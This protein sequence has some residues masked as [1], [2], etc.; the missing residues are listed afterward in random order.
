MDLF[1]HVL[2]DSDDARLE[3]VTVTLLRRDR[4]ETTRLVTGQTGV[5][6]GFRLR[7]DDTGPRP[8]E[9]VL[10]TFFRGQRLP[11]LSGRSRWSPERPPERW[12]LRVQPASFERIDDAAPAHPGGT[13]D[14]IRGEVRHTNGRLFDPPVMKLWERELGKSTEVTATVQHPSPGG[15]LI[16][17]DQG[18]IT[19]LY[20]TIED[21]SGNVIGRSKLLVGASADERIDILV[22]DAAFSGVSE[23]EQIDA[24]VS[25]ALAGADLPSMSA[26]DVAHLAQKHELPLG[27][28]RQY[29]RAQQLAAGLTPG[30]AALYG[31]LRRGLPTK[32][33]E[34]VARR[35]VTLQS[36]LEAAAAAGQVPAS[37]GSAAATTAANLR[38]DGVARALDASTRSSLGQALL[39][40]APSLTATHRQAFVETWLDSSGD[41][42]FWTDLA[43]HASY[44]SGDVDAARL[45]IRQ[46]LMMLG[47][48]PM[49]AAFQQVNP[50]AT[51]EDAAALDSAA[52][53][54]LMSEQI[55][56]QDAGAPS[57]MP[58]AN[59]SER[60]SN[61]AAQLVSQAEA[62]HPSRAVVEA[63]LAA[64]PTDS[65]E[66][67]LFLRTNAGFDFRMTQ[68]D[69]FVDGGDT[70][71]ITDVF[72]LKKRLR[73]L[74]RLYRVIGKDAGRH[75]RLMNLDNA[76]V[77][78]A[79]GIARRSRAGFIADFAGMLGGAEPAALVHQRATTQAAASQALW[80]MHSRDLRP[81]LPALGAMSDPSTVTGIEGYGTLFAAQGS[82]ACEGCLSMLG[83]AAYFV[84]LL[85]WL[86]DLDAYTDLDAKR[87][88]LKLLELSCENT[89]TVLPYTDLAVEIFEVAV[90]GGSAVVPTSTTR[91]T[92]ELLAQPEHVVTAA[93]TT[94][95]SAWWPQTLPYDHSLTQVRATMD[96]LGVSWA[97]LLQTLAT[98]TVPGATHLTNAWLGLSDGLHTALTNTHSTL[99]RDHWGYAS[100]SGPHPVI[101]SETVPW[102]VAL[103]YVPELMS[104]AQ[105]HDV[106]H[107]RDVLH[108][109]YV[110]G[111]ND[112][113]PLVAADGLGCEL[114]QLYV[115]EV[116]VDAASA[117]ADPGEDAFTR[118]QCFLRLQAVLGW[119]ALELDKVLHSLGVAGSVGDSG[120]DA[121]SLSLLADVVRVRSRL[122]TVPLAEVASWWAPTMDVFLD[123][124][125]R[126]NPVA[127][128]YDARF[129]DPSLV[130]PATSP[131]MLNA[132]R[133][134]LVP[135]TPT[136]PASDLLANHESE[137]LAALSVDS[138]ALWEAAAQVADDLSLSG[139]EALERKLDHLS[140]LMRKVSVAR[141]VGLSIGDCGSLAT[142]FG[143]S[144]EGSAA[145]GSALTF[146]ERQAELTGWGLQPIDL[147]WLLA[148]DPDVLG[149]LNP[150]D[151]AIG[152][153]LGGLRDQLQEEQVALA[154]PAEAT[155]DDLRTRLAELVA[156]SD[157]VEVLI[158]IAEK[159]SALSAND[160]EAKVDEHLSDY[161]DATVVRTQLI[162]GSQTFLWFLQQVLTGVLAV[163]SQARVE[164]QLG[165]AFGL[166]SGHFDALRTLVFDALTS[167]T[168]VDVLTAPGFV[169]ALQDPDEPWADLT[170][171]AQP[172]GYAA[173]ELVAKV[174]L[175]VGQLGCS[176]EA[177]TQW[178]TDQAE[179][180][181][182]DLSALPVV[183]DTTGLS[184]RY[185][186]LRSTA[187]W[188]GLA[189]R[190]SG[191]TPE[192]LDLMGVLK[193]GQVATF[194]TD[195]ASRTGWAREDVD[196]L[197]LRD[198]TQDVDV[199]VL[200]LALDAVVT[201]DTTTVTVAAPPPWASVDAALVTLRDAVNAD[202]TASTLVDAVA[203]DANGGDVSVTSL[204]AVRLRLTRDSGATTAID[205]TSTTLMVRPDLFSVTAL[206]RLVGQL[207][208]L[209]RL[210]TTAA[211]ALAQ[212]TGTPDQAVADSVRTVARQR[213]AST[214]AWS[215]AYRP[216]RDKVR[217]R[218]Q[219]GLVTWLL[220][221]DSVADEEALYGKYL[222]DTGM[223]PC[224][225]TSRLKQGIASVQLY[226]QRCFLGLEATTLDD[227]A[228]ERW[229]WMRQYRL[230]EA[231]RKVFLQ[232]QNWLTPELRITKSESFQDAET[233][234]LE[235]EPTTERAE[236]VM[237]RYIEAFHELEN[238]NIIGLV[239]QVGTAR[240]PERVHLFARVLATDGVVYRRMDSRAHWTPWQE[241]GFEVKSDTICPFV[242][243]GRLFLIW[244]DIVMTKNGDGN[245]EGM[246]FVRWSERRNDGWTP[247]RNLEELP[248]T[249]QVDSR[250]N[251]YAL[252]VQ[253]W[254]DD[255]ELVLQLIQGVSQMVED[256]LQQIEISGEWH[257]RIG[258]HPVAIER[259]FSG[260]EE[261]SLGANSIFD[262]GGH[263]I[264]EFVNSG[265]DQ[266]VL[267]EPIGTLTVS[268]TD[269]SYTEYG[270]FPVMTRARTALTVRHT[271]AW[272]HLCQDPFV[273]QD[274]A[275][276]FLLWPV[277]LGED[278]QSYLE[279]SRPVPQQAGVRD[280]LVDFTLGGQSRTA[281][282]SSLNLDFDASPMFTDLQEYPNTA[283]NVLHTDAV[284]VPQ[285]TPPHSFEAQ[286]LH[287]AYLLDILEQL[288]SEG[289]GGLFRPAADSLH[290]ELFAQGA[291]DLSAFDAYVDADIAGAPL[292]VI[293]DHP[294]DNIAF[295]P[296]SASSFYNWE[297][298]FH[299][300][301]LVS[302]QLLAAQRFDEALRWVQLIFD[303]RKGSDAWA[304]KPFREPADQP[305]SD[306]QAFKSDPGAATAFADQVTAWLE[307]PFD[308]HHVASLRPEAY[309][310]YT[311]TA[312]LDVLLDWADARFAAD[313]L[314]SLNEA[315]QL[316]TYAKNVLGPRPIRAKGQVDKVV[317]SFS[318]LGALDELS[319]GLI[320]IEELVP[321]LDLTT[322]V[323]TGYAPLLEVEY[324]CV[325]LDD[326]LEGYWDRVEM[327]LFKLRN[328]MNIDGVVRV[329]PLFQ[330]PIDPGAI[331][332]A[333]ASG[334]DLGSA[335]NVNAVLPRHRFTVM[336]QR[337][338]ELAGNVRSLG[339]SLLSALE[340]RDGEEMSLLRQRHELVM[341]DANL[342]VREAQ[343]T[344]A[345]LGLEAAVLGRALAE[346]R[347]DYYAGLLKKGLLPLELSEEDQSEKAYKKDQNVAR[348]Q[349]LA[350]VAQL[351]PQLSLPTG[352]EFGGIH[353][354]TAASI[355]ASVV[356]LKAAEHRYN[357]GAAGRK[358]GQVRR[359]QDWKF[360]RDLAEAELDQ[361]DEQI[362]AA[363]V[364][365]QIT[366]RELEN[367][368]RQQAH[369]GE[370]F[371]FIKDKFTSQ[372]L[373]VWMV[374]ELSRMHSASYQLAL[375]VA[376]KAEACYRH[377][378]G[379]PTAS[380]TGWTHWDGLRKGMLVGER[381][382][383]DL[384][385]M[386]IAYLDNDRREYEITKHFALSQLDPT[387]LVQLQETGACEFHVAEV[388]YDLDFPG[389]YFRRLKNVSVSLPCVAGPYGSVNAMLTLTTS[390]VRTSSD[391]SGGYA[392]QVDDARF[393]TELAVEAVAISGA[394]NEAG[395]FELSPSDGRYLPFERRGAIGHWRLELPSD[396][397]SLDPRSLSDV[398][399]HLRY[400]SRDGGS[401]LQGAV[402]AQMDALLNA[403]R[404]E[405]ATAA[406]LQRVL[407]ARHD[408]PDAWH[409]F[410][411]PDEAAT[412]LTLSVELDRDWFPHPVRGKTLHITGVTV[413]IT[414]LAGASA[415]NTSLTV[416]GGTP[417]PIPL[418]AASPPDPFALEGTGT[419]AIDLDGSGPVTLQVDMTAAEIT[420]SGLGDGATLVRLDANKIE[421]LVLVLHYTVS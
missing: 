337:S 351:I 413:G 273:V 21:G 232:P 252:R 323:P 410:L 27:Q 230:W 26:S 89:N 331:A 199:K 311:V 73:R 267:E 16:T 156:D 24:V 216:V 345:E 33:S 326:R 383:R 67:T 302:R 324:F 23:Y 280:D 342:A 130:D 72:A 64:D 314:E 106:E 338:K 365:V 275:R 242:C 12:V 188:L 206:D 384:E 8:S 169:D 140:R 183:E 263:A 3:G 219:R 141:A 172:D 402:K 70:T 240:S 59:E 255:R 139:P 101:P 366:E 6:G 174:G 363:E 79:H 132:G 50:G 421:D 56:G 382:T 292:A 223:D 419:V 175:L 107:L 271:P 76:G 272:L 191:G 134:E 218:Q 87:P 396:L 40:G 369:S 333:L 209:G 229:L 379:E 124:P 162:D 236:N 348:L 105:L 247:H 238:P 157:E 146:L 190:A 125:A 104:R 114:E 81:L 243:N 344:E 166:E 165:E 182:L 291:A 260:P 71:L 262:H 22:T 388:G 359:V 224:M 414:T 120:I 320:A 66:L 96:H 408:L 88:D 318:Q 395:V 2:R 121:A 303:P 389:Q 416:L 412:D 298:F 74:R 329:L 181:L 264:R 210:G 129:L 36:A 28:L 54:S 346:Q 208:L 400:T 65:E 245:F 404:S 1:G 128:L 60:R 61:Y 48:A 353:L 177:L 375:Q 362:A 186:S 44:S 117:T 58:G 355:G 197:V 38:A 163:V 202:P 217:L 305:I 69:G 171:A 211:T 45:G 270:Q 102:F 93:Y 122:S 340:K 343:V 368:R 55:D 108:T 380:F 250:V 212:V 335:L 341:M 364:R 142:A 268:P 284:T 222:I 75:T 149:E 158:D 391:T 225:L 415:T 39:K 150:S 405:Y 277:E 231:N 226:I 239:R 401:V 155:I 53:Q 315:L 246:L 94:L 31:L 257:L 144:M 235:Q 317:K 194:A 248:I 159:D 187:R 203:L 356:G 207:G 173:V 176:A 25:T 32:A 193:L 249:N 170:R 334:A 135:P 196:T 123:R 373:Y 116:F 84:D 220:A 393:K 376:R 387:A 370:V 63:Q 328:C 322:M 330:P 251:Y 221:N 237:A 204:P 327:Q 367:Q 290:P 201:V 358:A 321:E 371:S 115:G 200:D 82:C 95:G 185:P 306:W 307:H 147:R 143:V 34:L 407:S 179:L 293:A 136:T 97:E 390:E 145:P 180:S 11:V 189:G 5:D 152:D 261:W 254:E 266:L 350:S 281:S 9:Y 244:V 19:D 269:V 357:S 77:S 133:T 17:Y 308:P 86:Q 138:E 13:V 195:L 378:I 111:P 62:C 241:L 360:Q 137:L 300:P 215:K 336:L 279:D 381:L 213:H 42:T 37:T 319:N 406:G 160:Q 394:Q 418:T 347:R 310:L 167:Q 259:E 295:E 35:P 131:F 301:I 148:H 92:D 103:R 100:A 258:A 29:L 296:A 51:D 309:K 354:G 399:L 46:W 312:Y 78:S 386:E 411:F 420:S 168:L 20:V 192:W 47:Y 83:P 205:I 377:E 14:A 110:Q 151:E 91:Q 214:A 265:V 392:Q 313:T 332:A 287:Q 184:T 397:R 98:A 198:G 109:R 304:L 43:G 409:G 349:V 90:A 233:R 286:A 161:V 278:M 127:P 227:E 113:T 126:D 49:V 417:A 57:W 41:A 372:Q 154:A 398:V 288:R 80:S 234:L 385:R 153:L 52:W 294:I 285:F 289:V 403:L 10:E 352:T 112:D 4:H 253:V 118:L 282:E 299:L 18:A 316:Y 228:E 30:A 361:H 256:P 274:D 68:V 297:L 85:H 99:H 119:D 325:P 7:F 339:Q 283:W 374:S 15:Y 178:V 276:S 164:D